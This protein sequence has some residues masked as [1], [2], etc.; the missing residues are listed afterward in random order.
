MYNTDHVVAGSEPFSAQYV[1][2]R[3]LSHFGPLLHAR[4]AC[5]VNNQQRHFGKQNSFQN[6]S[7]WILC[8]DGVTGCRWF[9]MEIISSMQR[10][11]D[12]SREIV[13]F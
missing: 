4:R 10:C 7:F 1:V 12:V 3:P 13:F 11:L 2:K 6:V 5:F 9:Y 8:L